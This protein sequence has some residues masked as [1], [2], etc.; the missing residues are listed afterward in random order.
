MRRKSKRGLDVILAATALSA[1][2]PI[3]LLIAG[4][5]YLRM[6]MPVIFRQERAGFRG[7]PFVFLKFRTMSDDCDE[8]GSL[9]PDSQRL[10][11]LGLFLRKCSLDELPQLW[12]VLKGDMSLIGPRPLPVKYL[13]LYSREQMRRHDVPQGLVGWAG[14]NGRNAITWQRKFELDVWYV[15]NWSL[16]LD[17]KIIFM[18]MATVLSGYGVNEENQAT[19]R[20]FLGSGNGTHRG[21]RGNGA[22]DAR[23]V[24]TGSRSS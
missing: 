22:D 11:R 1:L 9:L 2:W 13:P 5:V 7:R 24:G 23:S 3:M 8:T 4:A 6:G 18:A 12:N 10:T 15:D 20:E 19:A 17:A 14:V 16:A 21:T